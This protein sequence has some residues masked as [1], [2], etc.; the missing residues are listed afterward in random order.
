MSP[1]ACTS[2][3]MESRQA[4]DV[5]VKE[6]LRTCAARRLSGRGGSVAAAAVG[7]LLREFWIEKMTGNDWNVFRSQGWYGEPSV[8]F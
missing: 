6:Q 4:A 3:E 5:E 8:I 1:A 7:C 2:V